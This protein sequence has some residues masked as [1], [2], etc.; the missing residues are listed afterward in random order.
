MKEESRQPLISVIVPVYNGQDYLENCIESIH[1]QTYENVEIIIVNDGSTDGTGQVCVRLKEKNPNIH[2]INLDDE[3]VSAAR[4]AG[5]DAAKGAFVTFVD[6]DDRLRPKM[7]EILYQGIMDTGSDVCGCGFLMWNCEEE[8]NEEISKRYRV[9]KPVTYQPGEYLE[10]EVLNG[11]SRCW[12]KLYRRGAI[13][14]QRFRRGLT[15]GEDMLFVV[16]LLPYIRSISEISYPG[17]GYYVNPS[18]AMNRTFT[19][20][21]M[22]QITCWEEARRNMP[23]KPG[24]QAKVTTILIVSI[25]LTVGKISELSGSERR[26]YKKYVDIC[27]AKVMEELKVEGAYDGLSKGYRIK[28]KFFSLLPALYVTLYHFRK[29]KNA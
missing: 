3:G 17:Y 5:L 8:W 2:V 14:K 15:I 23:D 27:R 22:D 4:N 18:G 7:L 24:V 28:V 20:R 13:G 19:P 25:M 21:Y 9:E 11:N 26:K 6:A 10:K 29:F 1:A 12:S 16:E